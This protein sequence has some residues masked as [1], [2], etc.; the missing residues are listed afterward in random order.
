MP[1]VM[2]PAQGH[3]YQAETRVDTVF[4]E[5]DQQR[6]MLTWRSTVPMRRSC[7]DIV[8]TIVGEELR[9]VRER[10][11]TGG[12]RRY[13]N[14]DEMIKARRKAQRMVRN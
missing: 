1:I 5:P 10:R 3:E 12:K 4:I 9:S 7:F 13:A 14:L 11:R 8:Q 2:I 6:F